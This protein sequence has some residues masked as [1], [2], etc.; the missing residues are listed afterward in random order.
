MKAGPEVRR[1]WP[2][3]KRDSFLWALAVAIVVNEIFIRTEIRVE[4]LIFAAGFLGAPGILAFNTQAK[5]LLQEE[6]KQ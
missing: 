4:A 1:R 3:L 6:E 5:R 2:T